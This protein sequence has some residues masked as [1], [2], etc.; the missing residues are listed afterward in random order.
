VEELMA[1]QN[2]HNH[3]VAGLAAREAFAVG[4]DHVRLKKMVV[5]HVQVGTNRTFLL[6]E[7]DRRAD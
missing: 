5:L 7:V 6:I 3:K 1:L 2:D 4:F